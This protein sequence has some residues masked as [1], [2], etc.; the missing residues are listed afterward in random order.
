MKKLTKLFI[1]MTLGAL[2]AI[3]AS[4]TPV[5]GGG[6]Q[7]GLDAAS[8]DGTF[9]QDVN[10]DQY[11][12]DEIWTLDAV[13]SGNAVMMFEF[14]G[15]ANSNTMG[16]Y[17]IGNT[18]VTLELFSG[19][20]SQG[21]HTTLSQTGNVF[22]ATYFDSNDV[23]MGQSSATLN[24][25][26][27]GFYLTSAQNNTF[28]SQ[29]DLNSDAAADGTTDHLVT[30]QGDNSEMMDP[31]G[32]GFYGQFTDNNFIL[33]WEDLAL[34]NS[35]RDYSDMVVMVE[36]F[37]PVPEPGTLGVLGLGLLGFGLARR[38]RA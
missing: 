10:A 27:F 15:F 31:D 25:S 24:S 20:A 6:L 12:P 26:N 22:T 36:S 34:N 8:Q 19:A 30:F 28:Y 9:S 23:Y 16:I 21:W 4:A 13:S 33:A 11:N 7:A 1:G 17:Q 5:F 14:A 35:D 2:S 18:G 38:K 3:P 37:I 29:A 32:D